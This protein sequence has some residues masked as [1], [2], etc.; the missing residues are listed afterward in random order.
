L[1]LPPADEGEVRVQRD[2]EVPMADGVVLLADRYWS[3]PME[4]KPTVLVRSPYGRR[5][6]Y[7][8]L[9]GRLLAERGF[10]AVVQSCRG[11]FGSG[12][13]FEPFRRERL[14]GLATLE[15]IRAREWFDGR[16][17]LLGGSYLGFTQWAIADAAGPELKAMST[18]MTSAEFRSVTYPGES[19]WLESTL[20]WAV[21]LESQERS[22]LGVAAGFLLPNSRLQEAFNCLP[23]GEADWMALGKELPHWEQWVRHNQP[24]DQWWAPTDFSGRIA[25]VSAPNHMIGGWYD[26]FL[27]QTLRDYRVLVEAGRAPY[28]TIGPWTHTDPGIVQTAL[29]EAV[30]WFRAHLLGDRALLRESPVRV[31]VL[32]AGAWRDFPSWPPPGVRV[33]HLH[34]QPAGRL[35]PEPPPESAADR[36]RYDPA[37]P[38]PNLGG[39]G[40]GRSTGPKDNRKLEARP[41]VLC[42]STDPLERDLEVMGQLRA[43]LFARSSLVHTD[44]FARLCDVDPA[45]RS[46]NV[47][48]ALVR[49]VPGR[50]AAE[51]DGGLHVSIDLWPTAYRFRRGHRLRLQVS[52]GA[53]PR[54]ARNLGSGEPLAIAVT[55]QAAEQSIYHDP[56]HPSRLTL[57]VAEP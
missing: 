16:I 25:E 43:E 32:G 4:A 13:T 41:D 48:D 42:Y 34:L 45:G 38:T 17:A 55:L 19:F 23:V 52:S 44:F 51:A 24:G 15:W 7:G 40:M 11:T 22:A 12:G 33:R 54:W 21:S 10:Q 18:S 31:F 9:Y 2:L 1:K 29:A 6:V 50:P 8:F 57:S 5:G 47:S 53:H 37:D 28:L 36:Y 20:T 27:P 56:A 49:V 14:D 26:I 3:A 39:A 46:S 30:A 35:A